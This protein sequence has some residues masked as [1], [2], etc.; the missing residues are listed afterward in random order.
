MADG[1]NIRPMDQ[2]GSQ[3]N[4]ESDIYNDLNKHWQCTV[5]S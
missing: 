4:E 1:E 2:P 5:T 3:K